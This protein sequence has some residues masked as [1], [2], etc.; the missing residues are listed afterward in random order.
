[1][2]DDGGIYIALQHFSLDKAKL[3]VIIS[4]KTNKKKEDELCIIMK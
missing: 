2:E 4:F 1:M 3:L